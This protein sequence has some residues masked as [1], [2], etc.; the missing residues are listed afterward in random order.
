MKRFKVLS[1]IIIYAIFI[2]LFI[3]LGFSF[4][5]TARG[6]VPQILGYQMYVVVT[7]SMTG[8]YDVG[9]VIIAKDVDL[10]T[11]VVGDVIAYNGEV[12][13]YA[14]KVVTH[15]IVSIDLVGEEYI[16][17]ARGD[18]NPDVDPVISG[19]Q[20]NGKIIAKLGFVTTIYSIISNKYVFFGIVLV[21]LALVIYYQVYHIVKEVKK[22][23]KDDV[24]NEE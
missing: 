11:L 18:N 19:D 16:I 3:I 13:T 24:S 17:I 2:L 15:R 7:D 23:D 22:D 12:G 10:S 9:D 20:V 21:P 6:K 14:G 1:M 5:Q 4:I 8:T